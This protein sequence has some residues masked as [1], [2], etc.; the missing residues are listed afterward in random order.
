MSETVEGMIKSLKQR[1]STLLQTEM[2]MQEL[3][4]LAQI[5]R[6]L[7]ELEREVGG[8]EKEMREFI[9]KLMRKYRRLKREEKIRKRH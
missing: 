2:N 5:L 9:E 4:K 1:V 6:V 8:S 3:Y 7:A